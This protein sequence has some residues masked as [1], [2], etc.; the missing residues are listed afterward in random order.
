MRPIELYLLH[1]WKPSSTDLGFKIPIQSHQIPH[2]K[3]WLVIAN[4][5]Q[6]KPF[7]LHLST[8]TLQT[9]ASM[10]AWGACLGKEIVQRTWS[11][12]EWKLHINCLEMEAVYKAFLHFLP[13]IRNQSVLVRSDNT[14]VV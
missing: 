7:Q 2:L 11:P 10:F 3:W 14:T 12:E 6:G 9:D 4:I 8:V 5:S 13:L 1:F